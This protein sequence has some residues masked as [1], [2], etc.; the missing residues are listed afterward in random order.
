[1]SVHKAQHH[2]LC[3]PNT[4]YQNSH[5]IQT[6]KHNDGRVMIWV[7]SFSATGLRHPAVFESIMKFYVCQSTLELIVR[8]C[9]QSQSSVKTGSLNR[10]MISSTGANPHRKWCTARWWWEIIEGKRQS[11]SSDDYG[12]NN[13]WWLKGGRIQ[14]KLFS[15]ARWACEVTTNDTEENRVINTL[16]GYFSNRSQEFL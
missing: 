16:D 6:I 14:D 1:M 2:V 12:C 11:V 9:F 7:F 3:K 15:T 13:H 4:A 8:L 10:A 5:L